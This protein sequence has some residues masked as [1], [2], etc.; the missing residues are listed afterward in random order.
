MTHLSHFFAKWSLGNENSKNL[1]QSHITSWLKVL[2]IFIRKRVTTKPKDCTSDLDKKKH[3]RPYNK[4]GIGP[5]FTFDQ[6]KEYFFRCYSTNFAK[7]AYINVRFWILVTHKIYSQWLICKTRAATY[8]CR[9]RKRA[10]HFCSPGVV[11]RSHAAARHVRD[12]CM[13]LRCLCCW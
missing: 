7:M 10:V 12:C 1:Q 11:R 2:N 4:M 9:T 13:V 6:F 5:T 3:S 8:S